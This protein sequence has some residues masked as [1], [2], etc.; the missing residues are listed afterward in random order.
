MI[1]VNL[2]RYT[3]TEPIVSPQRSLLD[4]VGY[5]LHTRYSKSILV[6]GDIELSEYFE[7]LV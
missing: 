7:A 3:N 6:V 1:N 4:R 2:S 5:I